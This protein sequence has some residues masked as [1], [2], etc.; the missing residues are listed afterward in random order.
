[1]LEIQETRHGAVRVVQPKGPL[2]E[3]DAALFKQ[4]LSR[5]IDEALGRVAVDMSAVPYVDSDGLEALLDVAESME[6][7][8]QTCKLCGSNPTI[9]EVFDLTGLTGMFE[10]FEDTASAARSYL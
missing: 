2:I 9:R 10:H 6:D 8:G 7:A 3:Q 1:M 5:A 4:R